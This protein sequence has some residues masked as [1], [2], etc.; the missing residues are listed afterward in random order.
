MPPN[1]EYD[2]VSE[3]LFRKNYNGRRKGKVSSMRY[4][5]IKFFVFFC[6]VFA[7]TIHFQA[8]TT[9]AIGADCKE[10]GDCASWQIC[11][12]AACSLE[13]CS[14]T[15]ICPP[16]TECKDR[17]CIAPPCQEGVRCIDGSICQKGVCVPCQTDGA[18]GKGYICKKERCTVGCRTDN[19]CG[20]FQICEA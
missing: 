20:A 11:K 9:P 2:G 8:C 5:D 7:L 18:C 3:F 12:K 17:R 6:F 1:G 14:A 10:D 19:T 13:E 4:N 16:G 15:K